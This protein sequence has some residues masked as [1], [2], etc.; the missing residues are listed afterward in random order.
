MAQRIDPLMSPA[1]TTTRRL[2]IRQ[3]LSSRNPEPRRVV[4]T[5]ES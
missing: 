5:A 3:G 4:V 2:R 1:E